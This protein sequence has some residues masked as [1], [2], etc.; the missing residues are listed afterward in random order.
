MNFGYCK[1]CNKN[2]SY[3]Q[4][5]SEHYK[6]VLHL[7]VL[8]KSYASPCTLISS[9]FQSNIRTYFIKNYRFKIVGSF[10]E[11]FVKEKFLNLCRV[12]MVDFKSMKYQLK[13]LLFFKQIT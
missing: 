9:A 4:N 7:Q 2:F 3:I 5:E 1:V 13:L 11:N 6:S 8:Y 12:V 10:L